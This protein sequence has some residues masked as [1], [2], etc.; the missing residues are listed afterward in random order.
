[1]ADL[2]F[3][4]SWYV[5]NV[6]IYFRLKRGQQSRYFVYENLHLVEAGSFEEARAKAEK[7]GRETAGDDS[8]TLRLDDEPAERVFLGVRKILLCEDPSERPRD[9]IEL[10]YNELEVESWEALQDL[11]RGRPT[12]LVYEA[13]DVGDA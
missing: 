7:V 11:A 9:G 3:C 10:T 13:K 5:A 2:P 6:L 4:M 12:P 1:M 8:G